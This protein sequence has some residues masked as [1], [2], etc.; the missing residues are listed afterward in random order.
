MNLNWLSVFSLHLIAVFS[1]FNHSP[2]SPLQIFN[3]LFLKCG[4]PQR[5]WRSSSELTDDLCRDSAISFPLSIISLFLHPKI[6]CA[7]KCELFC[8]TSCLVEP[9]GN[10]LL[11]RADLHS[12]FP[13]VRAFVL[14]TQ[15][16]LTGHSVQ[17][18]QIALTALLTF[19]I[20]VYVISNFELIFR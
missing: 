9:R 17:G 19:V 16:C 10:F 5:T 6:F 4:F 20:P 15:F 18:R 12:F 13:A 8:S 1:C 3:L 7:F 14:K 11:W 2:L